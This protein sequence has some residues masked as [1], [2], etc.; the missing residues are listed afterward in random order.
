MKKLIRLSVCALMILLVYTQA[1]NAEVF[2]AGNSS[3]DDNSS[4]AWVAGAGAVAVLGAGGYF[5]FRHLSARAAY[6]DSVTGEIEQLFHTAQKL[7]SEQR[8]EEAALKYRTVIRD[9]QRYVS[10]K[11]KKPFPEGMDSLNIESKLSESEFLHEHFGLITH[12]RNE[13]NALP[14]T[15][16]DLVER[17]RHE[18]NRVVKSLRDTV[19][20]LREKITGYENAMDIAF[21]ES[22]QRLNRIDTMFISVYEQ[23]QLNFDVKTR[24]FYNRAMETEDPVRI[25]EFVEDCEYYQ[26]EKNWCQ[27]ARLAIGVDCKSDETEAGEVEAEF[28]Y[29]VNSG[30]IETIN[31]FIE[32]YSQ[33]NKNLYRDFIR[34]AQTEIRQLEKEMEAE[35][36]YSRMHPFFVNADLSA[37]SLSFNGVSEEV[38]TLIDTYFSD[39]LS[40]LRNVSNL[41]FPAQLSIDFSGQFPIVMLTAFISCK[42]DLALSETDPEVVEIPGAVSAMNF[43]AGLLES[44]GEVVGDSDPLHSSVMVVRLRKNPDDFVTLYARKGETGLQWFEFID[45]TF[46]E[47]NNLRIREQPMPTISLSSES[48]GGLLVDFFELESPGSGD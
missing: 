20:N 44:T 9:W 5:L 28:R 7:F 45:L 33:K 24:F 43:L 38:R 22:L 6:R 3:S 31:E 48:S 8:Y 27:K 12:V 36:Q 41:R 39:N 40:T 16:A 19:E 15:E 13:S 2:S 26:I 37:F 1:C 10:Y 11:R 23:E 46:R 30:R 29:A 47:H 35:L 42:R 14:S 32:K 18:I 17:N 4:A 34:N 21:G 25:R